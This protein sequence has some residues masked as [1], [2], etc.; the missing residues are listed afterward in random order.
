MVS[1]I[2]NRQKTLTLLKF[3]IAMQWLIIIGSFLTLSFPVDSFYF[4]IGI[5]FVLG[6]W[7]LLSFLVHLKRRLKTS[8]IGV[9]YGKLLAVLVIVGLP[10]FLTPFFSF[11][12]FVYGFWFLGAFILLFL[13]PVMALWYIGLSYRDK[14]TLIVAI[15]TENQKAQPQEVPDSASSTHND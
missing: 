8:R 3:D 12:D 4:F 5:Y 9:N 13:G 2:T 6:G 14:T 7:Q 10:I 1:L 15:S 11:P